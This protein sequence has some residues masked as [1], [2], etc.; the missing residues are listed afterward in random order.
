MDDADLRYSFRVGFM[1]EDASEVGSLI[2]KSSIRKGNR[3]I[4]RAPSRYPVILC[5]EN[6]VS[7][8]EA[9]KVYLK[10]I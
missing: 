10:S 2:P 5:N 7:I 8:I 9:V 6:A 1:L 3:G 4:E